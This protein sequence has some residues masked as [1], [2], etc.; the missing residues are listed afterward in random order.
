M[1]I[2]VYT[3]YDIETTGLS[4]AC[5]C[6]IIEFAG[7]KYDADFNEVDRLHIY[8]KPYKKLPKKIVELT[9]ITNEQLAGCENRFQ[10]LPKIRNFIGNTISVCHNANFD[11]GFIST[12]CL[13]QGLPILTSYICT[14]KTYKA[15]TGEKSA[16]LFM[17]C[18]KFGIEL[19]NAHT[20]IADVEATAKLFK[21]LVEL[22]KEEAV[23]KIYKKTYDEKELYISLMANVAVQNPN[24]KVRDAVC[25]RPNPSM[26]DADV[27]TV[28]ESF[29]KGRDPI[30]ICNAYDF[31]ADDVELL[32]ALW[33]NNSRLPKFVF[34]EDYTLNKQVKTMIDHSDDLLDLYNIHTKIYPDNPMNRGLYNYF[35][36]KYKH[37]DRRVCNTALHM[38]FTKNYAVEDIVKNFPHIKPCEITLMFVEFAEQNK[39]SYRDYIAKTILSRKELNDLIEIDRMQYSD[40][41]IQNNTSLIRNAITC[42]LYKSS[43]FKI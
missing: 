7:I 18:E 35:W 33:L 4:A 16:K 10:T 14:L 28:I 25:A 39:N 37:V 12:M 29:T 11:F 42:E 8:T 41:E 22:D 34:L 20:A 15:L 43:F 32:F 3:V 17:A 24:K 23:S 31:K 13:Q 5:Q 30:Q 19:K 26:N 6:E 40:S 9:G 21:K 2:P 38:L 27:N 1:G 36:I